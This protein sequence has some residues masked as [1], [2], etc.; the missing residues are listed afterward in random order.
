[1]K[2]NFGVLVELVVENTTAYEADVLPGDVILAIGE[3]NVKSVEN[4]YSLLDKYE[5]KIPRIKISRDGINLEKNVEI[6]SFK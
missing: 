2:T 3:D 5:G 4:Y 1:M 6:R